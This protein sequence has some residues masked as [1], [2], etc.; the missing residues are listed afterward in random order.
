M[1][2]VTIGTLALLFDTK[3]PARRRLSAPAF[4]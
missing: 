4:C 3:H 1:A 2:S